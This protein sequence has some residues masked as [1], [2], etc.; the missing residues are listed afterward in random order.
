VVSEE[1][2]HNEGG[3]ADEYES[4]HPG[5][6]FDPDVDAHDAGFEIRMSPSTRPIRL[7][8]DLLKAAAAFIARTEPMPME[9]KASTISGSTVVLKR[10]L[11]SPAVE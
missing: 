9:S 11:R 10:G 6:R 2:F 1:K 7:S 8:S 5:V 4:E 3:D